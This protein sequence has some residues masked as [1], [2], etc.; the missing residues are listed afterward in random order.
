MLSIPS[1]ILSTQFVHKTQ[2]WISMDNNENNAIIDNCVDSACLI[3]NKYNA[4]KEDKAFVS[5]P[6]NE[7]KERNL[8]SEAR[9]K[10]FGSSSFSM[11][12]MIFN[13]RPRWFL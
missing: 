9:Y 13:S 10:N 5:E 12:K 8:L 3:D 1:K 11:G 4:L 2:E 7:I 6:D